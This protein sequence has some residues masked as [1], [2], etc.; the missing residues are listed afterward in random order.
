MK[1]EAFKEC[2]AA[3]QKPASTDHV[4]Y[5][6]YTDAPTFEKRIMLTAKRM[7]ETYDD[8]P[9]RMPELTFDQFAEEMK[10][11]FRRHGWKEPKR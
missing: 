2:H 4:M 1:G 3:E 7:H 5:W 6:P 8:G 9:Q 10:E 11:L